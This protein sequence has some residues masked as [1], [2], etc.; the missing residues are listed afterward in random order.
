M[1]QYIIRVHP[2]LKHEE[3]MM[4]VNA[5]SFERAKEILNTVTHQQL[6]PDA[7]R[8]AFT[9]EPFFNKFQPM[10]IQEELSRELIPDNCWYLMKEI[11]TTGDEGFI[12]GT[13]HV[14]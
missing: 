3:G 9:D 13:Y 12:A 11:K 2:D 1:N 10:I 14:G 4:V 6:F 8:S 7:K 5:E